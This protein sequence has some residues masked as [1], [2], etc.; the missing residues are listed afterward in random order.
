MNGV[1]LARV[2]GWLLLGALLGAGFFS[3]LRL[4]V[5]LYGSRR[6]P[7]AIFVHLARWALLVTALAVISRAGAQPLLS[8]ALGLLVARSAVIRWRGEALR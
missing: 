5:G 2:A 7:L 6:W 8:A 3:M 4:N 1:F